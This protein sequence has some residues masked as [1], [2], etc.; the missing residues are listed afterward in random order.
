MA[1][2]PKKGQKTLGLESSKK[3]STNSS[4]A[5]VNALSSKAAEN[6]ANDAKKPVRLLAS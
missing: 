2:H 3:F 6:P 5:K 1:R 4:L